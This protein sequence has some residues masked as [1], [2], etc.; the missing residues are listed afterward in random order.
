MKRQADTLMLTSMTAA[1][2]SI[3]DRQAIAKRAVDLHCRV[4]AIWA[5]HHGGS[6]LVTVAGWHSAGMDEHRVE[7]DEPVASGPLVALIHDAMD[8]WEKAY[9]F[10][11]EEVLAIAAAAG[12][13]VRRG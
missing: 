4:A 8:R 2:V 11:P 6:F 7:L 12:V 1:H 13:T 10:T 5:K 9:K 3:E